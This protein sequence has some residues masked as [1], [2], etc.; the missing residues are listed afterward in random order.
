M[1]SWAGWAARAPLHLAAIG[2]CHSGTDTG[3]VPGA[4]ICLEPALCPR[5]SC[6]R[7]MHPSA[8]QNIGG[9]LCTNTHANSQLQHSIWATYCGGCE[10]PQGEGKDESLI[11][12]SSKAD[13]LLYHMLCTLCY[14]LYAMWWVSVV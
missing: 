11:P 2:H 13:L 3:D 6:W 7:S 10:G 9:T 1:W 5:R 12:C 4:G 14:I 8:E